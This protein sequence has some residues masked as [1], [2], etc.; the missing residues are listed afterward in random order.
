MA[1]NAIGDI[2]ALLQGSDIADDDEDGGEKFEDRILRLALD[3]LAGRDV[4]EA[5][6]LD[7][8]SIEEAQRTLEEA[9]IDEML[10]GSDGKEYVGPRAPKLPPVS[11]SMNPQEFTLA[12]L[13]Q[14]GATLSEDGPRTYSVRGKDYSERICFEAQPDDDRRVVL[15]APHTPA[16]QRLVKRTVASGVHNVRDGDVNP[17]QECEKL[18]TQWVEG[19]GAVCRGTKIDVVTRSFAGTALVR[20]RA[21]VAHDSYEQLVSYPC[22]AEDHSRTV[23]GDLALGSIPR[24]IRNPADI[25]I[26]TAKLR[27]A[28]EEDEAIAEFARFYEERREHEVDAAG[29]DERKRQKLEDDFTPRFDMVLAGLE[30]EVRRNVD[31]TVRYRFAQGADYESKLTVRP[32]TGEIVR[33]PDADACTKTGSRVP[34]ECLDTCDVSGAKVLKHLLVA[35]EL[36]KRSALPEFM[37]RC[38]VTGKRALSDE[39]EVSAVT[40]KKVAS[41]LLKQSA[42]SGAKAEPEH[43]G[44]CEFT[45]ALA[46][47]SELR[48]SDLSAKTYRADQVE[49][50]AVSGKTG[51]AHEFA[52]CHETR[53]TIARVEAEHCDVTKELLRPGVL[54]QC[55]LTG[56]RVLPSLLGTCQVTRVRVLKD[57]LVTSSIS[58]AALLPTKGMKS[59]GG[60]YCL[61]TEAVTCSWS[62]RPAHPDDVRDCALTG[63]TIHTDYVTPQAPARLRPLVEILDGMRHNADHKFLWDKV[64][65]HLTRVLK[66]GN[67]RIEAAILSPS[68]DMLAACAEK[69][70]LLG[71]RVHQVG[72]VYDVAADALVGKLAEGK[73]NGGAWAPR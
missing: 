3:A 24:I 4:E 59:A 37:D 43:F 17:R 68:H 49:Q 50:S 48:V 36:S 73:R 23:E 33:A 58:Q 72:A 57:H 52:K 65:D 66:G 28:G 8:A 16:F 55:A 5:V 29:E 7:A 25:G 12:A 14:E 38:E 44:S 53:Q 20:V 2:D 61:P 64:N 51:H 21:T 32:G 31:V 56:K 18:A 34:R 22:E 46:L 9:N 67:C 70:R 35:S 26:D 40:G 15:Y 30:G 71:L 41:K 69:K 60:K 13:D 11:R 42:I 63:L 6:R 19:F 10:G 39:L 62:G 47:K 54:Q 27:W 1:A 45:K